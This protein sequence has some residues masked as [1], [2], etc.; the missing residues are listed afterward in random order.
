MGKLTDFNDLQ[1]VAGL[2]AVSEQ[3]ARAV[4]AR[5]PEE[6]LDPVLPGQI[7]APE[8]P[9]SILPTWL[10]E[11]ASAVASSTQTP[12]A[13]AVMMS[14]G[15]LATVLQRRFEVSPFGDDDGYTEPLALWVLTA[16]PS[17]TRKT[18]VI[19]AL[20]D[21]LLRWEK[22]QRDRMRSEIAR[23]TATRALAKKKIERLLADGAKAKD[24]A[25]RESIR[26]AIQREEEGMPEEIRA[27]RLFT[28]DVTPERLQAMLVE[29]GE[30]MAVLSDEAG[31]F[32][33][34]AGLYNGGAANIDVFLQG[35]AGT[36]M[37][38]DRAGRSAHVDRPALSFGLA[39][40]PGVLTDVAG[41]KRFRDSGLLARFLYAM[42]AS[43]VGK[44]DVRFRSPIPKDVQAGYEVAIERLLEN[45][46]AQPGKPRVLSLTDPAREIW[47]DFAQAIEDEQGEG[48]RYES[49]S[50]WTSKLPG[51]SARIAAL[52]E[53]AEVGL[54][55]EEVSQVA[56]QRAIDLARLL[57][58]HAQSAFGLLGTDA[59]DT[60]A[61]AILKWAR[62]NDLAEFSQRDCQKAMEG[63]FRA[64]ER[65]TKALQRLEQQHVLRGYTQRNKGT[66]PTQMYRVNP[67]ALST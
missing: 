12:P 22:V 43:N 4:P 50:D 65:L 19:R 29:Y 32:L 54:H 56:M 33:N 21:C 57:I 42:P 58:V 39:L 6:W 3:I 30:R 14:L 5:P 62:G 52:L 40:Q 55:A 45:M 7:R 35:H 11:M 18:A 1:A 63:R 53:L 10:G 66:R 17:G 25:E 38:V 59:V 26:E 8:I 46:P 23:V 64:F 2:D 9:A 60:D 13:L 49:I 37:R 15:V 48:G 16:L 44:R 27:P 34:M 31:I 24:F 51:A 67:K 28:G 47:L 36:A 20:T 41:S 61:A